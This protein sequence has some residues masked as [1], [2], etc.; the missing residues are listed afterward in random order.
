MNRINP[1]DPAPEQ[2]RSLS[3]EEQA[4]YD[5][6]EAEEEKEQNV[7]GDGSGTMLP[8]AEKQNQDDVATFA[9]LEQSD[10]EV[11][12]AF[13]VEN[14]AVRW[15]D[16]ANGGDTSREKQAVYDTPWGRRELSATE[17]QDFA[18]QGVT[19]TRVDAE[20]VVSLDQEKYD[21]SKVTL[22]NTETGDQK[23]TDR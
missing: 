17:V 1:F 19:V 6:L 12:Q 15:D 22:I 8:D 23:T 3:P 9:E 16:A 11:E 18:A 5:R 13:P 21:L 14:G 4:E 2:T 10:S 20:P 7:T